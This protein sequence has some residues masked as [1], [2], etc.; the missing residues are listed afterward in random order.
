MKTKP[1][2]KKLSGI[3]SLQDLKK[4]RHEIK[5]RLKNTEQSPLVKGFSSLGNLDTDFEPKIFF[6][7]NSLNSNN[8]LVDAGVKTALSLVSGLIVS[9]FA[10]GKVPKL[11]LAAGI[12][13]I[14]PFVIQ[15]IQ[16]KIDGSH[17][18]EDKT[19]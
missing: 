17:Q 5:S 12:A 16:E 6:E 9:R 18:L 7:M 3:S 4:R 15:K 10:L 2:N 8:Q 1:V 19:T 13:V 14:T 11:L